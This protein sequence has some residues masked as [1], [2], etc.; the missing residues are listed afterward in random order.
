MIE[1]NSEYEVDIVDM[2]TDGE[3]IAKIKGYTTFIKGALKGEKAKIKITK[4]N[5]DF[6]FARLLEILENSDT[7]E[8]PICPNFGRCGGCNLQHMSYDAQLIHK[9]NIVK[10]TLKKALGFNVDV[11]NIVGMG[12]PY[13]YRN[14]AQYPVQ[15]NKIGFYA[16][17]SHRLW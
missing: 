9:E 8:E 7:R 11:N 1:K 3:G 14:K 13:R 5:K 2:G 17:R 15:D 6:G 16:D 4:A 12:V 10:N